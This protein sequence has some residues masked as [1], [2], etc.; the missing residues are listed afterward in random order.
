MDG[1]KPFHWYFFSIAILAAPAAPLNGRL[2]VRLGMRP[3]IRRALW[4]Q[5]AVSALFVTL[6]ITGLLGNEA[7][8]WVYFAWTVSVFSLMG[9]TIGN[10]NALALE[11]LGHI[12]GLAASVMGALATVTGAIIGAAIGQLY[13]GTP[14]PLAICVLVLTLI[15]A[16]IMRYMPREGR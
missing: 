6:F 4:S 11:P 15:A 2:V 16:V 10:L 8:F 14:L 1:A 13:N 3:L 7:E 5:V 9:F 12:A